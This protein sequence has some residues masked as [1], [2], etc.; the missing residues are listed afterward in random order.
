M[1]TPGLPVFCVGSRGELKIR[2]GSLGSEEANREVKAERP[3]LIN[4]LRSLGYSNAFI[5][6]ADTAFKIIIGAHLHGERYTRIVQFL[7]LHQ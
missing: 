5:F 2:G 1:E 7:N 4:I 3:T 6:N